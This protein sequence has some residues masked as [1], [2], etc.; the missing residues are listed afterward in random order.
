MMQELT[1]TRH[2]ELI[3]PILHVWGWQIP[4]YL[5]LGGLV[6]GIMVIS[7]YL[8]LKGQYRNNVFSCFYLPHIIL[9]LLSLGMLA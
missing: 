2:N 3:D 7:G 5:F 6:A 4:I 1:I 8:V 9:L